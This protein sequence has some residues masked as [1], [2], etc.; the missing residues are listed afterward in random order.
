MK[1]QPTSRPGLREIAEAA[2]CSLMTVSRALNN[3]PRVSAAT[4]AR[5]HDLAREL[6]YRP[7][8]KL[9]TL[10]GHLRQVRK[11]S[12]TEIFAL[13][14]PDVTEEDIAANFWLRSLKKGAEDRAE[15]LGIRID[16]FHLAAQKLTAARLDKTLYSRGI[17]S[18][19][20]GPVFQRAHGH[21]S[22]KWDRYCVTSIGLGLW[23]PAFHRV[24]H[25]H[26]RSML[27]LIR[28]LQHQGLRRIAL[29]I[30][31]VLHRR[32]FGVYWAAFLGRH[33]L[34]PDEAAKLVFFTEK[35]QAKNLRRQWK[36]A[37]ADAMIVAGRADVRQVLDELEAKDTTIGATLFWGPESVGFAGIDQLSGLLGAAAVDSAVASLNR[38]EWG[39]PAVPHALL[40]GGKVVTP[41]GNFLTN[42]PESPTS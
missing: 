34:P 25:D 30:P 9:T 28:Y 36:L 4:K 3:A 7:D 1:M 11:R 5:I 10:M 12:T 37:R 38:S 14:W 40:I 2:N 32:M 26:F 15:A 42:E 31:T 29:V 21:I 27:H 41:S 6:G 23:R 24:H 35:D 8:P 39:V 16:S 20:F 19:I 17:K 22:M 18:V 13:V 33:P